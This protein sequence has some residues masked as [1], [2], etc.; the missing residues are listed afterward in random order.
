MEKKE[1]LVV[2]IVLPIVCFFFGFAL[3]YGIMYKYPSIV[4]NTITRVEKDVSIT[5]TGIAESVE[6]VYDAVVVVTTYRNDKAYAS[7]T[8]FVY[9]EDKSFGYILTNYHVIKGSDKVNIQLTDGNIVET[10]VLGYDQD[11]DIAV[12]KIPKSSVLSVAQLGDN[13]KMRVGDTTFTVGAPVD[14]I[15]SWTVTRGILSGKDRLVQGGENSDVMSV[16]QTDAAI[17]NG[18][19]GGPLCNANGEVIGITSM[20]LVSEAVEGMGFAIKIEDATKVANAIEKGEKIVHPYIGIAMYDVADAYYTREYNYLFQKYK[21][22][23]GVLVY[24]VTKNS[25]ADKAGLLKDDVITEV[26]GEK[27][28]SIGYLKY[29]LYRHEIGDKVTLTVNRQGSIK[30]IIITL[31]TQS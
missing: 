25:P 4:T 10:T 21:I 2:K 31:T 13:E 30:K 17:N 5:D 11:S 26:D 28:S 12:L 20:K 3:M 9:K 18:N 8:G 22:T 29:Y 14:S 27:V 23:S 19:S 7:G 16:L 1:N 24:G 6:K 15:F